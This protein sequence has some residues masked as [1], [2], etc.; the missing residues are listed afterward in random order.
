[1]T[2][3][4]AGKNPVKVT[5]GEICTIRLGN[6]RNWVWGDYDSHLAPRVN[7][8]TMKSIIFIPYILSDPRIMYVENMLPA[9]EDI[10]LSLTEAVLYATVFTNMII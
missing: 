1:M 2:E 10:V 9:S 8:D 3:S 6:W 5:L 4:A 7:I